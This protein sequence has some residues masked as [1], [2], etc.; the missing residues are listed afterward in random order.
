MLVSEY[1]TGKVRKVEVLCSEVDPQ[2]RGETPYL[3]M[4]FL[5]Y[6]LPLHA[7]SS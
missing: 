2:H 7:L 1:W 5:I 6:D 3:Y 4:L